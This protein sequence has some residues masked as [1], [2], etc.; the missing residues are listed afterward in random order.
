MD[1]FLTSMCAISLIL[2]INKINNITY[3]LIC[4]GYFLFSIYINRNLSKV[5]KYPC[6]SKLSFKQNMFNILSFMGKILFLIQVAIMVGFYND[7]P[8][9]CFAL[10]AFALHSFIVLDYTYIYNDKLIRL[11]GDPI[12]LDNILESTYILSFMDET[13][14]KISTKSGKSYK[15]YF[16][17]EEYKKF[18]SI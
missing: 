16:T 3:T 14:L 18:T 5:L 17:Q 1:S 10:I 15:C 13:N 12:L 2:F 11:K 4:V 9:Q 8:T 7:E 6:K